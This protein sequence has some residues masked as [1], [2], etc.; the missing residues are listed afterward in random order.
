MIE[1]AAADATDSTDGAASGPVASSASGAEPPSLLQKKGG[2]FVML[3]R[4]LVARA[5]KNCEC[6]H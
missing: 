2:S 1:S 3:D 5:V 6:D 4:R